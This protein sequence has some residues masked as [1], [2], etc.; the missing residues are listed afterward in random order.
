[1]RYRDSQNYCRL[2]IEEDLD[3]KLLVRSGGS[4]TT[5]ASGALD[6]FTESCH[7]AITCDVGSL[8]VEL[9]GETIFED[10]PEDLQPDGSPGLVGPRLDLAFSEFQV[11]SAPRQSVL[12]DFE[13]RLTFQLDRGLQAPVLRRG[14]SFLPEVGCLSFKLLSAE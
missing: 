3:W 10:S 7:V 11:L 1:M 2:V 6:A 8:L 12:G 9:N 4:D 14:G 5:I 13:L